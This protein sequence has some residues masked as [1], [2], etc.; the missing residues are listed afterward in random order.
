M[1]ILL[2][3]AAAALLLAP[4]GVAWAGRS[5]DFDNDAKPILKLQ[6][7]LLHY[8]KKNFDV[9]ETGY[10]QVP[11]DENRPPP[12]PYIFRARHRG[13]GGP[14]NITLLIQPGPPGHILLV[15]EDAPGSTPPPSQ[16]PPPNEPPPPATPPPAETSAPTPAPAA[17]SSAPSAD[18]PSGPIH[19]D[20]APTS[21]NT[22]ALQPPPDPAPSQ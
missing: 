11:G 9:Q 18:T 20:S 1:K 6:P 19:L 16:P 14:Y 3:P 7:D 10:A 8:V 21:T 15:K 4:P 17:P 2:F 13:S 12:P 5:P 22:P